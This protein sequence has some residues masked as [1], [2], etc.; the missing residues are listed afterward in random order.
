M[1]PS[2]YGVTGLGCQVICPELLEQS[3]KSCTVWA[4]HSILACVGYVPGTE[5]QRPETLA[6]WRWQEQAEP[7]AKQVCC[8]PCRSKAAC[9]LT[10][11]LP[12]FPGPWWLWWVCSRLG[13]LG[14]E[15]QQRPGSR[16]SEP[17]GSWPGFKLMTRDQGSGVCEVI[18]TWP[19][20]GSQQS[21]APFFY[22]EMALF[23]QVEVKSLLPGVRSQKVSGGRET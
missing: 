18:N 23:F 13:D 11:R 17:E 20:P 14:K 16:K 22:P 6:S 3:T 8:T 10:H 15:P 5:T 2:C 4:F 7:D 21:T 19:H 1:Y 12:S 9:G